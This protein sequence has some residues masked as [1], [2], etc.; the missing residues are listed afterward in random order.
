MQSARY[1]NGENPIPSVVDLSV[2]EDTLMAKDGSGRVVANW[3]LA[4]VRARADAGLSF[5]TSLSLLGSQERIL[6]QDPHLVRSIHALAPSLFRFP[7]PKNALKRFG[8]LAV[9]ALG[10]I[11]LM[12]LVILPRMSDQLA[13]RMPVEKEIQFGRSVT[14]AVVSLIAEDRSSPY[15]ASGAG[16]KALEEM[17]AQ[18]TQLTPIP[19]PELNVQVIDSDLVNALAAPG[20]HVLLFR[21][22]IEAADHPDEIAAVLA[23]EIGHIVHRDPTRMALRSASTAGVLSLVVGDVFGGT[24]ILSAANAVVNASYSRAAERAADDYALMTLRRA[25]IST[26]P[27]AQF[28]D[29]LYEQYGD[30]T[31]LLSTHPQ[32]KDRATKARSVPQETTFESLNERQWAD[33]KTICLQT[34][35]DP[36]D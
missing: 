23:H 31:S 32:L 33:F 29:R 27:F 28:F 17:V 2:N 12:L 8:A 5:V 15:C 26:E 1:C 21:G 13:L 30:S 4:N 25:L 19:Y 18:L 7:T 6:V 9:A 3:P 20:A 10:T 11:A 24:I 36:S 22:L 14:K 35:S 34:R 16:R